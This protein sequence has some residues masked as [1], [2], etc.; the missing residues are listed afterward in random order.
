MRLERWILII[1]LR[2]R[3]LFRREDVDREL[4]EELAFHL[5]QRTQELVSRGLDPKEARRLAYLAMEG[6]TRRAEE[7]RDTRGWSFVESWQQDL[8]QAIRSFRLRPGTTLTVVSTIALAIG[9]TTAVYSVVESVL[10]RP[11][12][13]PEPERLA[14]IWQ[15]SAK[16]LART[17]SDLMDPKAPVLF[18]WL[19][20]DTGFESLGAYVDSSYVLR[21]N[22]GAEVIRGQEATSGVFEAL[23]V[24][25][26][27]G[28]RLAPADDAG[29]GSA[30]VVL[31]EG[32]WRNRFGGN[33]QVVG[34]QLVLDGRPHVVVGVMPTRFSVQTSESQS[35]ML[36]GG[37]PQLWTPLSREVRVGNRNAFV[38][39]RVKKGVTIAAAAERLSTVHAGIVESGFNDAR[40]TGVKVRSL[41]DSAVGDIRATM[42]FL[43]VSVA[44]VLVVAAVNIANILTALGLK[45]QRELAVRAALG[46]SRSRLV[47]SVFVES[48]LLAV[49]GGVGG[50]A[51]AWAG[52]PVLV[53]LLPTLPRLDSVAVSL[54]VLACGLGLT[55][56]TALVVGPLPAML[57]ARTD[58]Q[59]AMRSSGRSTTSGRAANRVRATLAVAEVALAFVLLTGAGLLGGSYWRLMSVE[60]G[61]ETEGLAAMWVKPT[62]D[63]YRNRD[64]FRSYACA[65]RA[66][67]GGESN[68][69][70]SPS[71]VG[72]ER[73]D[74]LLSGSRRGGRTDQRH[75]FDRTRQLLRRYG[76]ADCRGTRLQ[77]GRHPEGAAHRGRESNA[78]AEMLAG[79]ECDWAAFQDRGR[80]QGLGSGGWDRRRHPTQGACCADRADGPSA[81]DAG[82]ARD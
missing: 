54:G 71:A 43:L 72:P 4:D 2:L 10:L 48:A 73:G 77:A 11:L 35:L 12:P 27:L 22:A 26:I 41:L 14:R 78:G 36:P 74:E 39:G 40:D 15:T 28:R 33:E 69:N 3:S 65:A 29:G 34:T 19:N 32:F 51:L 63:T 58:P 23:G 80:S 52:L 57:A 37:P 24:L 59:D 31:S 44:L 79:R 18:E 16:V 61:F 5:D 81:G 46:A 45:R 21:A 20:A 17:G 6:V 67:S 60:R 50:I 64:Q 68:G 49:V 66:D 53:R 76:C 38:I 70:E 75:P 1:P 47:R 13:Y 42:W 25:P 7:C 8:R 56:T 30:V 62:R 82:R 9:A 55:I